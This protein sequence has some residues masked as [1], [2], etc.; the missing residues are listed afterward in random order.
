MGV[1][2]GSVWLS[3]NTWQSVAGRFRRAW[4]ERV[5]RGTSDVHLTYVA[6]DTGGSRVR[7]PEAS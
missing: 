4:S 3:L 7:E 2:E 5:G 1:G 6:Q